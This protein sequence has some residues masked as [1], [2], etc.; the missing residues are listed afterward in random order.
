M[1]DDIVISGRVSRNLERRQELSKSRAIAGQKGRLAQQ[2]TAK[3]RKE[4]K[5]RKEIRGIYFLPESFEVVFEDDTKQKL[6]E[7]EISKLKSGK[8]FYIFQHF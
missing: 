4:R 7:F 2:N 5:E 3:E 8:P 1:E 6:S